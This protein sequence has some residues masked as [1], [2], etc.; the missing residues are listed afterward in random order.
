MAL[1]GGCGQRG[2]SRDE[3]HMVFHDAEN[4]FNKLVLR[5]GVQDEVVMLL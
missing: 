4:R 1:K 5:K 2:G 3:R